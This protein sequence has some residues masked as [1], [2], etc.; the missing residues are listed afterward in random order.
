MADKKQG[1]SKRPGGRGNAKK[2]RA[3]RQKAMQALYQWD[4]DAANHQPS[5]ILKQ[6]RD[7]QNM[8]RVDGEYFEALFLH[9][10]D[11][12]AEVDSAIA[13]HLDRTIEQLDPVE[14]S[15]LRICCAELQTQ[16]ATPYRVVV[17]EALEI[18]KDFGADKGYRYV[19][20]IADKLAADIRVTEYESTPGAAKPSVSEPHKNP[21]AGTSKAT[22][23]Y[24]E[25]TK[26]ESSE[27]DAT[28]VIKSKDDAAKSVGGKPDPAKGTTQAR[29]TDDAGTKAD[30]PSKKS[31]DS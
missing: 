8:D 5:D 9:V 3:A 19:N 26:P 13:K 18:S 20:G 25:S 23:S 12:L 7:M 4:F 17:N 2:R 6:F 1:S 28:E 14:R 15:V 21:K 11:N 10:T 31:S 29:S 30:A 24:K 16:L 27:S 22:I